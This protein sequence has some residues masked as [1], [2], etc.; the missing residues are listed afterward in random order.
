MLPRPLLPALL[1]IVVSACSTLARQE[2]DLAT[3]DPCCQAPANFEYTHI[4]PGKS[5]EVNIKADSPVYV[6]PEGKSHFAAL[7]L[8]TVDG[9]RKLLVKTFSSGLLMSW[10]HVFCSAI[11]FLDERHERIDSATNLQFTYQPPG[12]ATNGYWRSAMAIPGNARFAIVHTPSYSTGRFVTFY[13]AESGYFFPAGGS[14]VFVPGGSPTTRK[15]PCGKTGE[16]E[17]AVGEG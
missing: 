8:P 1:A 9:D 13:A 3:R 10:S 16:L 6:F 12:W 7:R 14:F 11:T 17:I 4:E 5:V 2:N 15:V